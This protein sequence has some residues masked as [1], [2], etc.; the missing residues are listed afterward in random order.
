MTLRC[1]RPRSER[2]TRYAL[3][4]AVVAKAFVGTRP[5]IKVATR[6]DT[7]ASVGASPR[8]ILRRRTKAA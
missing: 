1:Q 5:D 2:A 4:V 3:S 8:H 7:K 6:P